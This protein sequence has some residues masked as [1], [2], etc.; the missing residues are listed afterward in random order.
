M[1]IRKKKKP[2]E[3]ENKNVIDQRF[4]LEGDCLLW[5]NEKSSDNMRQPILVGSVD[6]P[7]RLLSCIYE[8]QKPI[9][10]NG[11]ECVRIQ[12]SLWE[13]DPSQYMQGRLVPFYRGIAQVRAN[14]I[15]GDVGTRLRELINIAFKKRSNVDL[16]FLAEDAPVNDE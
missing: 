1:R 7:V 4:L 14:V 10:V 11:E 5:E 8:Y 13:V 2:I 16:N 15:A 3:D 9:V 12:L 6:L